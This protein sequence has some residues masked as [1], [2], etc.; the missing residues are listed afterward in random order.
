MREK[1]WLYRDVLVNRL[2]ELYRT[3]FVSVAM[4][5]ELALDK[6]GCLLEEVRKRYSE[7]KSQQKQSNNTQSTK[8]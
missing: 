8:I 3:E 5:C 6:S 2:A 4:V 7:L 1:Y